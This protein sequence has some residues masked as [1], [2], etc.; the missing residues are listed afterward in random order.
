MS[1]RGIPIVSEVIFLSTSK[2]IQFVKRALVF[3]YVS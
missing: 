1:M 3:H 2:A